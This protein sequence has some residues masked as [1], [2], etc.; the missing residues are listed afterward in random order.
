MEREAKTRNKGCAKKAVA[1]VLDGHGFSPDKSALKSAVEHL[2]LETDANLAEF[3]SEIRALNE[4]MVEKDAGL[5]AKIEKAG[6]GVDS[7]RVIG[8]LLKGQAAEDAALRNELRETTAAADDLY[9]RLLHEGAAKEGAI[10]QA[11]SWKQEAKTYQGM[12]QEIINKLGIPVIE[13]GHEISAILAKLKWKPALDA[14]PA[15]D[16]CPPVFTAQ[17]PPLGWFKGIGKHVLEETAADGPNRTALISQTVVTVREELLKLKPADACKFAVVTQV[18]DAKHGNGGNL[19]VGEAYNV[20]PMNPLF[21]KPIAPQLALAF[22][23]PVFTKGEIL[24][25]D[26]SGREVAG[27][28]R[29]PDKWDVS[30]ALFDTVWEAI[31]RA[32][33]DRGGAET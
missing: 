28:L 26:A 33:K 23:V 2:A 15:P 22:R 14:T 20:D 11:R 21:S 18:A 32:E 29:K 8:A 7:D 31:E 24:V 25:L 19:A 6:R 3:R 9:H 16:H 5:A 13:P 1:R 30:V 27:A 4:V 17:V 10:E 12:I